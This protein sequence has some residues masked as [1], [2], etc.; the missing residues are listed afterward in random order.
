[1]SRFKSKF[2]LCLFFCYLMNIVLAEENKDK[3]PVLTVYHIHPNPYTKPPVKDTAEDQ[4]TEI[5]ETT[6]TTGKTAGTVDDTSNALSSTT[7]G[8]TTQTT[9]RRPLCSTLKL[10]STTPMYSTEAN[11]GEMGST[12][13]TSIGTT[14]VDCEEPDQDSVVEDAPSIPYLEYASIENDP[15]EKLPEDQWTICGSKYFNIWTLSTTLLTFKNGD[16]TWVS[17]SFE[18]DNKN[19]LEHTDKE[20]QK[21]MGYIWVYVSIINDCVYLFFW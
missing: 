13:S 15:T 19:N 20:D 7:Q 9:K 6:E 14:T 10:D 4:T 11:P 18:Y 17:G 2:L 8:S 16:R 3:D 1:M 21:L 12:E 5:T